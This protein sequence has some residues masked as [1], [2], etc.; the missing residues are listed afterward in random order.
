MLPIDTCIHSQMS[1]LMAA[2]ECAYP[3][4]G[5]VELIVYH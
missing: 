2:A 1:C 3:S 5:G 4:V